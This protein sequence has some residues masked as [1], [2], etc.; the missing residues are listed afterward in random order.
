M[1]I[2]SRIPLLEELLGPWQA[3][4]GEDYSGYRNH[5]YRMLH[6]CRALGP[7]D[8]QQ[9]E[10]LIIAGAFHD[11]GLWTGNTLDYLPP[12]IEV[13]QT[14]LED[15]HGE[16]WIP[17][18]TRMIDEHHKL[19]AYKD[20]R[21]PLVERFR[22]ADL[23]DFSRGLCRCGLSRELITEVQRAFPNAGF[24]RML[25]RRAGRWLLKHPLNP[26]PMMKR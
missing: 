2:Q 7:C 14:Y 8:P 12:S 16:A 19:S 1:K 6:Y 22:Q 20:D 21:Y 24:H 3:T 10:K 11:I 5:V 4:I 23:V 13:A 25:A 17:E 9:W 26:A 15:N 18:V